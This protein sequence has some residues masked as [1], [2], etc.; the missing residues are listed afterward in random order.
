[1]KIPC[2]RQK[3]FRQHGHG[4]QEQGGEQ[5]IIIQPPQQ[6]FGHQFRPTWRGM[7]GEEM[8]NEINEEQRPMMRVTH[9]FDGSRRP[10]CFNCPPW[11]VQQQQQQPN[12]VVT[13]V[14]GDRFK[15]LLQE[16]IARRL[17]TVIGGIGGGMQV[18]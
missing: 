14:Y 2:T 3:T 6:P 1:M 9:H 8:N 12:R 4:Q 18:H 13:E 7:N 11:L 16:L 10:D 5:Q 15:H 17:G